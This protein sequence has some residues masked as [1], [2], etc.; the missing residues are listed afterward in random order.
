MHNLKFEPEFARISS[1]S[2][3]VSENTGLVQPHSQSR[4]RKHDTRTIFIQT[5]YTSWIS[6]IT[7][8][9]VALNPAFRYRPLARSLF[10]KLEHPGSV[11]WQRINGSIAALL[12]TPRYHG[13]TKDHS[14]YTP[15]AHTRVL[16]IPPLLHRPWRN[17][18]P[19]YSTPRRFQPI[20]HDLIHLSLHKDMHNT[21]HSLVLPTSARCKISVRFPIVIIPS[22]LFADTSPTNVREVSL[23]NI[24]IVF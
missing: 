19:E 15:S 22:P 13:P 21:V 18:V 23:Q 20:K 5:F 11:Q 10:D 6:V 24:H 7:D 2:I 16:R 12:L 4:V 1:I 8:A 3:W 17:K 9:A 14:N